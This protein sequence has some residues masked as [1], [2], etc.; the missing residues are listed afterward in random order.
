MADVIPDRPAL[1]GIGGKNFV[2]R[3]IDVADYAR[4]GFC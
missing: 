4:A 2:R 1:E 3:S